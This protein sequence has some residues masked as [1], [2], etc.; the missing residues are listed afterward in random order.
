M[1]IL[2]PQELKEVLKCN[3]YCPGFDIIFI[4]WKLASSHLKARALCYECSWAS[5][6]LLMVVK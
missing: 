2:S 3:T 4:S 6:S 5:M 1:K